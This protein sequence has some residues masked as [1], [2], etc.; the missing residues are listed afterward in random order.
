MVSDLGQIEKR[1][2]RLEKDLKKMRTPELEKEFDLLKR[3][4]AHLGSRT[5][6][7]RDG[8]D[9]RGQETSSRLHVPQREANSLRSQ[10]E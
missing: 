5:P 10:C 1:L 8:D 4:N 3:A 6:T 2:E 9:A 7:A